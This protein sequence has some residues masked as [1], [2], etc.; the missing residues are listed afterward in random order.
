M[1]LAPATGPRLRTVVGTYNLRDTGGYAATGG[2]TRWG[3]LYR[4]DA[5]HLIDDDGRVELARMRVGLVI[6]LR[7]DAEL[8]HSPSALDGLDLVV[9]HLPI[10][11]GASPELIGTSG[12]TLSSLYRTIIE[13]FGGNLTRAVRAI[14]TAGSTPVLVHCTAGK[15][16]TGLVIALT[17]LAVGVDRA[18]VVS[19]YAETESNLRGVWATTMLA[20]IIAQAGTI[21]PDLEQIVTASPAAVLEEIIDRIESDFG[22]AGD[23]L[24]A[25]GMPPEELVLLKN[26]LIDNNTKEA[27]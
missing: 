22:S 3:K 7:D 25:N 18:S 9:R 13:E 23:Y 10:F 12:I 4:S 26:A 6:D 17:L 14:A 20:R 8:E 24:L 5:L 21:S 16:R 27:Q 1:E 19:D 11:Q 15:D 2:F